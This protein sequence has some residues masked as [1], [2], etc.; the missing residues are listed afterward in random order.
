[1][2]GLQDK[3]PSDHPWAD[4]DP[5]DLDTA[6]V[7]AI[8]PQVLAAAEQ[9]AEQPSY[10]NLP[11]DDSMIARTRTDPM[12]NARVTNWYGRKSFIADMTRPGRKVVRICDPATMSVLSG[13]PFSR[14][15]T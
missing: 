5:S 13:R 12:T 3:L 2:R 6:A 7:K 10:D 4:V 14:P 9:E 1:M 8:E 15:P 11:R